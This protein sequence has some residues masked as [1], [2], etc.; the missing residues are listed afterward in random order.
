MLVDASHIEPLPP[1]LEHRFWG[2]IFGA[3]DTVWQRRWKRLSK[4]WQNRFP[5]L[6]ARDSGLGCTVRAARL[7]RS[8]SRAGPW[9]TFSQRNPLMLQPACFLKHELSSGHAARTAAPL[10]APAAVDAP[11]AADF[12]SVLAAVRTGDN[13]LEGSAGRK[14]IRRMLWAL[15]EAKRAQLSAALRTAQSISLQQD[16]RQGR[17]MLTFACSDSHLKQSFGV[18]GIC[19]LPR[20]G[21][22]LSALGLHQGTMYIIMKLANA[23][24]GGGRDDG[25]DQA[26]VDLERNIRAKTELLAADAAYDEQLAAKLLIGQRGN[27]AVGAPPYFPHVLVRGRDKA[28]GCR[29]VLSRAWPSDPYL[30]NVA[31]KLVLDRTTAIVQRIRFSE[32]FKARFRRCVAELTGKQH[33]RISDLA[34]AKHRFTSHALPFGRSVI[35]FEALVRCAQSI[36]DERGRASAEGRDAR[37]WL[38]ALDEERAL[39]MALMADAGDEA[40]VLNRFLDQSFYDKSALPMELTAFLKKVTWLVEDRGAMSTGY[41]AHMVQTLSVAR[42]IFV[43][44]RPRRLGGPDSLTDA[45][46]ASCFRRMNNWLQ[47]CRHTI[48][49]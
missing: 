44:D 14:K 32:V 40:L 22:G 27:A 7:H 26:D 8:H 43:D 16:V 37:A 2:F 31:N 12:Q 47:L 33:S 34:S 6:D 39:T 49:A 48:A 45:I 19:D 25:L 29:R 5:W 17:L 38:A 24:A 21:F 1:P 13:V 35:F 9:A 36:L 15:A 11:S 46:V 3:M 41:T 18:V 42:T 30:A 20:H 28:H 10:E 23:R 4:K